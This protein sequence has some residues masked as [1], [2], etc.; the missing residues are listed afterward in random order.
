MASK[1]GGL[2][3]PGIG[4]TLK[5][6]LSPTGFIATLSRLSALGG[7]LDRDVKVR[8]YGRVANLA[9]P[10]GNPFPLCFIE[11]HTSSR[12]YS[13]GV[14]WDSTPLCWRDAIKPVSQASSSSSF[15]SSS[16]SWCSNSE[17]ENENEDENDYSPPSSPVPA[18][19]RNPPAGPGP[20]PTPDRPPRSR[21]L[22]PPTP[23]GT[24]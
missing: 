10:F 17:D 21:Q 8:E 24:L 2:L 19:A 13:L 18:P 22:Q 11:V 3:L 23:A 5:R 14:P 1:P 7:S 9:D 12:Y 16:A 6:R 4:L 20:T 15:S